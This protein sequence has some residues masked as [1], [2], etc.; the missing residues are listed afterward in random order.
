MQFIQQQIFCSQRPLF[1]LTPV[2]RESSAD[3]NLFRE[4]FPYF[5]NERGEI[6][7]VDTGPAGNFT[8]YAKKIKGH[9]LTRGRR[10]KTRP[11]SLFPNPRQALAAFNDYAPARGW[12]PARTLSG[13]MSIACSHNR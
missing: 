3:N 11:A 2:P 5:V 10:I 12:T 13:A 7:T 6:I 1:Q 9:G 4:F 8:F